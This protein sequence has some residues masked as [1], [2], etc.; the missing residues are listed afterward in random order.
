MS[1]DRINEILSK[2]NLDDQ[3]NS[4]LKNMVYNELKKKKPIIFGK[5]ELS[6][7][8]DVYNSNQIIL[9][10]GR[11][12]VINLMRM[13]INNTLSLGGTNISEEVIKFCENKEIIALLDGD[14][15]G[16]AIL[17]EL[18]IKMKIDYVSRAP[19]NKEIEHLDLDIL[20]KVIENKTKVIK[21]EFY[22]NKIS[23]LEFLKKN[24]LTR[25][26]KLKR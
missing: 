23:L 1:D 26:Y 13:D 18:L 11:S 2:F 24:Q 3:N 17:K 25:K 8:P 12:D 22:E 16:D 15:G 10:E 5:N 19:S 14:R 20:K 21:S 9:V 6:A 4:K 7:G